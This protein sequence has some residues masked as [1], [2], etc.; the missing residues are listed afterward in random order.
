MPA[1]AFKA[2]LRFRNK[3][4]AW[5]QHR[6]DENVYE[7]NSNTSVGFS[8]W[9]RCHFHC[10]LQL[11]RS[12]NAIMFLWFFDR[13]GPLLSLSSLVILSWL[14]SLLGHV[15]INSSLWNTASSFVFCNNNAW[16][17]HFNHCNSSARFAWCNP[18]ELYKLY[19]YTRSDLLEYKIYSVPDKGNS[20]G[21][22][23]V[24]FS[25]IT[26]TVWPGRRF[27]IMLELQLLDTMCWVSDWSVVK[28]KSFTIK[29]LLGL[30]I[31]CCAVQRQDI[32][33]SVLYIPYTGYSN[34]LPQS[35]PTEGLPY[36]CSIPRGSGTKCRTLCR[37]CAI[38]DVFNRPTQL[39]CS[40][41][42]NM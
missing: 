38:L 9:P 11:T 5:D 8:D 3:F 27:E 6:S 4:S 41:L 30:Y 39:L 20:T 1:R 36:C 24:F 40:F 33:N 17:R 29:P 34:Q 21:Y 32:V 10:S 31:Q 2:Q 16:W 23:G 18:C 42:D 28:V 37:P 22:V 26:L 15:I 19:F 13:R 35:F 12:N 25:Y 7:C 14:L